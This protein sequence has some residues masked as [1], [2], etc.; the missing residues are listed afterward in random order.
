MQEDDDNSKKAKLLLYLIGEKGRRSCSALKLSTGSSLTVLGAR[1]SI[2]PQSAMKLWSDTS[3]S[4][5]DQSKVEV[6]D[7]WL[8]PD[9]HWLQHAILGTSQTP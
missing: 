2:V 5:R 9:A 4:T 6:L 8:Q 1:G 7:P 3:F